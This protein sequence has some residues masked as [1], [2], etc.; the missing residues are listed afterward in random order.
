MKNKFC[1]VSVLGLFVLLLHAPVLQAGSN[2]KTNTDVPTAKTHAH[3]TASTAFYTEV[4]SL[5]TSINLKEVGLSQKAFEYA[6]K[7]FKYLL[8]H[9]ILNNSAVISICDFSQSS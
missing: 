9:H 1:S 8:S 6:Y 7:G 5:Y 4:D 2:P 3:N